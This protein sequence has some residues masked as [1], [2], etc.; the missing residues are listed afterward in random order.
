MTSFD[1]REKRVLERQAL[2]AHPTAGSQAEDQAFQLEREI[3]NHENDIKR[4][5][6][7]LQTVGAEL[8]DIRT[9]LLDF[10][11][12][13]NGRIVYLCWKLD[14]GNTL[15]WFHDL[16]SGFRGRQPITQLNRGSFKGLEPG[17]K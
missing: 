5:H 6:A 4:F 13:Y 10:Y 3:D 11:S 17:E 9:G 8:K 1:E 7:E 15:S 12:R 2:A 16:Q 14:E